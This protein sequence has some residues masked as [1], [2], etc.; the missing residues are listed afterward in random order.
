M[1]AERSEFNGHPTLVLKKSEDDK[2]GFTFGLTKAR[3][4]L[5]HIS[6]I[7]EFVKEYGSQ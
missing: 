4:I 3:L 7:E 6:E 5:E 2:Y 1:V